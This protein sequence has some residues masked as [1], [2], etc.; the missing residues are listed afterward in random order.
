M[1]AAAKT[2]TNFSTDVITIDNCREAPSRNGQYSS[3]STNARNVSLSGRDG[4]IEYVA[5]N[6]PR[7]SAFTSRS[8]IQLAPERYWIDTLLPSF[9]SVAG[10]RYSLPV[11]VKAWPERAAA[12]IRR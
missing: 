11:N 6:T 5:R 10:P 2:V 7:L 3:G 8:G 9:V 4:F 12:A 1:H